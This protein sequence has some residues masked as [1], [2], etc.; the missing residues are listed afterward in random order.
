MR[1]KEEKGHCGQ[2]RG[3]SQMTL[4]ANS[5]TAAVVYLSA[6]HLGCFSLDRP[7][8][9]YPPTHPHSLWGA[10]ASAFE[11]NDLDE[12]ASQTSRSP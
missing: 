8:R 7:L 11:S 9:S 4:H 5:K 1:K 6:Q 12:T 10:A 2:V 3:E